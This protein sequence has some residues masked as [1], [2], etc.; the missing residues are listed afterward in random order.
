MCSSDLLEVPKVKEPTVPKVVE[1]LEM[2]PGL[3]KCPKCGDEVEPDWKVCPSCDAPLVS[4][5]ALPPKPV[6]KVVAPPKPPEVKKE[7]ALPGVCP[8]CGEDVEPDW[9]ACPS[10][11]APLGVKASV[12]PPQVKLPEVKK[13]EPKKDDEAGK[14][15]I[16][17]SK[18]AKDKALSKDTVAPKETPKVEPKVE[19]KKVEK[20]PEDT[21]KT[22]LEA[23]Q[24]EIEKLEK[25]GKDVKK[26]KSLATLASSFLKGKQPDKAKIYM[27]RSKVELQK[28]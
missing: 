27:E 7:A 28:Q 25:S 20:P 10:C 19:P 15:K 18:T 12:K 1:K 13:E 5:P 23:L 8:K 6:E 3:T 21:I 17:W 4:K 14:K 16:V 11:D 22:D 24:K 26:A 9:K 2:A